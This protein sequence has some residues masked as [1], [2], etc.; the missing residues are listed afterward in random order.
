MSRLR[1]LAFLAVLIALFGAASLRADLVWTPGQ[2]WRIEGGALAGLSGEE[3]RN[4]LELMNTA[5]NAEEKG[6]SKSAIKGYQKVAKKYPNSLYAAEALYRTGLLY[7]KRREYFKSFDAFQE[8]VMKY[9]SSEK[10]SQVV[11]EQYRIAQLLLDG[12]RPYIWGVIPG[13]KNRERSIEYFE[14]IVR[15]APYSDYA[16]LSLMNIARGHQKMGNTEEAI[17]ALDRMINNYPKNV[18]TPDAYL[19]LAQ[20][21]SSLV[22]GAYYDQASTK[23]AITYFEDYLIQF[24]GDSGAG[25]AEKGLA[26]MKTMLAQ[27]KMILADYY[28]KYRKNYTAA[29]VFYNEAITTYPDSP[30]AA[31]ARKMLADVDARLAGQPAPAVKDEKKP[32][33]PKKKRFWLF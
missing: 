18:L 19:K 9:P 12:A 24:P 29:K 23:E 21:H 16:P 10:F 30:V 2:G 13:F 22:E 4:A 20:T 26:D 17:D 27:S 8:M 5:R 14:Q 11:A 28:Y 3:G 32:A 31:R 33:A 6:S 1:P 25:T 7:E 15:N